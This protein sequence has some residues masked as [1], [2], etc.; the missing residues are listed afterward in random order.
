[1]KPINRE[2]LRSVLF[3]IENSLISTVGLIAG[4]SVGTTD[5]QVVVL[6]ATVAIVIEAVAMGVGEYLSDDAVQELDKIKRHPDN[7]LF[8]GLFMMVSGSL[9]GLIPLIPVLFFD[10]PTSLFASIISALVALFLLGYIKGRVLNTNPFKGGFKILIVGGL[11]TVVGVI[12]G[13]VF[14]VS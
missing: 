3:G 13:L 7:P 9:A 11:A 10:Y 14:R 2:Y 8:S 12:V 6:G 4:I 1:M 5:K